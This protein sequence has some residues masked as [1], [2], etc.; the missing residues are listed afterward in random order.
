MNTLDDDE[1]RE[2]CRECG[3]LWSA[4]NGTECP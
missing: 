1:E 4:H 3:Q 2:R